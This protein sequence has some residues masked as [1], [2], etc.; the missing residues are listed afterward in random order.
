MND[1]ICHVILQ[2][3]PLYSEQKVKSF[4]MTEHLVLPLPLHYPAELIICH[5][6]L[7]SLRFSLVASLLHLLSVSC[8]WNTLSRESYGFLLPFFRFLLKCH[9]IREA[10]PDYPIQNSSVLPDDLSHRGDC[11]WN[12]G[13]QVWSQTSNISITWDHVPRAYFRPTES[14]LE[15]GPSI[16]IK[17]P[18]SDTDDYQV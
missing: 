4:T 10:L 5:F 2:W 7:W 11:V 8:A 14:E 17:E 12:S 13:S 15:L 18:C 1:F 9:L 6:L 16:C 3:L